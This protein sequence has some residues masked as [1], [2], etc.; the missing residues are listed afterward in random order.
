MYDPIAFPTTVPA[1]DGQSGLTIRWPEE[2]QAA[3]DQGLDMAERWLTNPESDWLWLPL[4]IERLRYPPGF[5]R[6]AFEVG[7]LTRLHQR[8]CSPLGGSHA[9]KPLLFT[10]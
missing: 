6:M 3:I 2:C 7:Y 4:A 10:L 1:A 9:A 5:A 8:L